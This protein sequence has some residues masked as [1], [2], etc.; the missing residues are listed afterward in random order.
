MDGNKLRKSYLCQLLIILHGWQQTKPLSV[1]YH[2]PRISQYF[3]KCLEEA[4]V[5]DF[6]KAGGMGE[7][8]KETPFEKYCRGR[9]LKMIFPSPTP[10]W[11]GIIKLFPARESLVNPGWGRENPLPFFTVHYLKV[12]MGWVCRTCIGRRDFSLAF[13]TQQDRAESSYSIIFVTIS[14]LRI[15]NMQSCILAL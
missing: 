5:T 12:G 14:P 9:T 2:P 4:P 15:N 7:V 3:H 8:G 10:L 11:P 1:P 13:A 6:D